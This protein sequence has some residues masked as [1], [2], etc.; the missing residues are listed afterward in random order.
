MAEIAPPKTNIKKYLITAQHSYS[1][2]ERDPPFS[3]IVT[4]FGA[5]RNDVSTADI[6]YLHNDILTV[7]TRF[8][9]VFELFMFD[10]NNTTYSLSS[11]FKYL[12]GKSADKSCNVKQSAI[13]YITHLTRTCIKLSKFMS[14]NEL[15][16]L[17]EE[18]RKYI[19][20]YDTDC[21]LTITNLSSDSPYI[22]NEEFYYDYNRNLFGDNTIGDINFIFGKYKCSKCADSCAESCDNYEI[23]EYDKFRE[24][25]P[26]IRGDEESNSSSE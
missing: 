17:T 16:N 15:F 6:K 9:D 10:G 12:F 5:H 21:G 20:G 25:N 26:N 1:F 4:T 24:K 22:I 14:P 13:D 18:F 7:F 3:W 23:I 19:V 2:N 11:D 8:C